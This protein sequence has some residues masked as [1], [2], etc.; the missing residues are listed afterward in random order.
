MKRTNTAKWVDG[1]NR[2][3]I[4]VQKDGIRK[5]F[6]CSTPGRTGQR[7]CNKKADE[8]LDDNISNNKMKVC[9]VAKIYLQNKKDTTSRTHYQQ[10]SSHFNAWI[11]PIIGNVRICN[12]TEQ[13]FQTVVNKVYAA[14]KSKKTITN[15]RGAMLSFL[16]FCR[17]CR[18]TTLFIEDIKI[19]RGAVL[20]GKK[21]LQ[22]REIKKLF[23]IDTTFANH[24]EAP[25]IYINA[26]RFQVVT[27]LRPGEVFGLKWTD[28]RKRT[29]YLSRSINCYN[30][31]TS[32]KNENARRTIYLSDIAIAILQNQK[33]LLNNF[34]L[35]SE[36]I[37]CNRFSDNIKTQDY[38]KHWHKYCAFNDI[39]DTTPY[40]LRHT[41]VSA[42][43]TIPEGYLKQIVGHSKDMDTY[44]VYSHQVDGDMEEASKLIQNIFCRIITSDKF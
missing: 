31:I 14:G 27:G 34:D 19:P 20:K 1:T 25:E 18:L 43:K 10:Y 3:Q 28:I 23:T 16:K 4:N 11:N 12:L 26:Y 2:W 41:F 22:P 44:G 7:E 38:N 32:G 13:H 39:T 30:E 21:I 37:F 9:E 17:S 35:S 5:T 29:L 42:I 36:Y 40:E 33:F 15:I 8:W 24:K 6:V